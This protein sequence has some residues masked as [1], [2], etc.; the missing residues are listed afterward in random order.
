M[1][2]RFTKLLIASAEIEDYDINSMAFEQVSELTQDQNLPFEVIKACLLLI[3]GPSADGK[4]ALSS[5]KI[6]RNIGLG[7]LLKI[8]IR[9]LS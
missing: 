4:Y 2:I 9:F 1:L 3:S 6:C 8:V 5:A 7:Q